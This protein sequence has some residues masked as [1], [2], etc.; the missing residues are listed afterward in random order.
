MIQESC[1][2]VCAS[3]HSIGIVANNLILMMFKFI[4]ISKVEN[5]D[6][7]IKNGWE[8]GGLR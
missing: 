6:Y 1:S 7:K 2:K 3:A 4:T 5:D 8:A